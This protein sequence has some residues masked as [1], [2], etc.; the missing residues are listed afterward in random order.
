MRAR[1]ADAAGFA[2]LLA[3][4]ALLGLVVGAWVL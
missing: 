3:V 2:A 1:L 4:G